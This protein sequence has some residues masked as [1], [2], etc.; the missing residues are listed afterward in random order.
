M[1]KLDYHLVKL[2]N[3]C[4]LLDE[5]RNN[6]FISG[7]KVRKLKGIL[8]NVEKPK[9]L[10][11]FGSVYSSHCLAS[12]YYGK[13][14]DIPV[15][16]IILSDDKVTIKDYPHLTISES[17]GAT[18]LFCSKNSAYG[19]IEEKK[20]ELE[21]YYWVPGGG[22]SIHAANEY[23]ELFVTLIE[24]NQELGDKINNIILP[25]GT[26]TTSLGISNGIRRAG[27][28]QI[29]VIGISVSRNENSCREAIIEL[30]SNAD[31]SNLDIIDDYSGKYEA[32]TDS[33][34]KARLKFMKQTGILVD[35][36][37]NAK[38]IEFFYRRKMENTLIVNTG[39]ML[40]NLL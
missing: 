3:N 17:F 14:L 7:N 40:N 33:T 28:H 1:I 5:N 16:L 4:F 6:S 22:H 27:C 30:G 32:R 34:E 23:E 29:R 35:P 11:T 13:L 31:Y 9:G 36:I 21:N 19:F 39:G 26:G 15:V 25:Y 18:I 24:E 10:L 8:N 37:Y 38:S 20:Q 12:S 2:D